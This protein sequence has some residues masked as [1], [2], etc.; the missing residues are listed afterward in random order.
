METIRGYI[1][2]AD[3]EKYCDIA[4]TDDDEAIER[5]EYVEQMIDDYVGFQV[6][7]LKVDF[8]GT[9]TGGSTTEIEDT[10]N[11]S[12]LK[13]ALDDK[14]KYCTVQIMNGAMVGEERLITGQ[15]QNKIVFTTP[16]EYEVA[17]GVVYRLY[18]LGKFPR[19]QDFDLEGEHYYKYIP[20]KVKEAC[21]AQF[22]Y[23]VE[24]G[25]DFLINGA[26]KIEESWKDYS[27]K[28]G[29]TKGGE[30]RMIAPKAKFLLKGITNRKGNFLGKRY[31][32]I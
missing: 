24:M 30:A 16:L 21:L 29:T 17:A 23:L 32:A 26:N 5:M 8:I 4:I 13:T 7:F 12:P 22:Q 10:S 20:R 18:Q 2:K 1:T 25:D 9:A 19:V 31:D 3:V 11:G 6:K 15:E 28:L 14:F 27:Y